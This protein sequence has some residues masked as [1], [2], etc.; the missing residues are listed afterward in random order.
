[1]EKIKNLK[2]LIKSQEEFRKQKD[3][4]KCI[5][6]FKE[7]IELIKNL[8]DNNKFDIISKLFLFEDQTNY[9]K[10][11][12]FN[13]L[14]KNNLF[15]KSKS[16]K[17]KYYQLLID[18]FNNNKTNDHSEQVTKLKELYDKS[19][20][21]NF[22]ELDMYI[23]LFIA[24]KDIKNNVDN[25][26][27]DITDRELVFEFD[28]PKKSKK[29]NINSIEIQINNDEVKKSDTNNNNNND[30]ILISPIQT[31][32]NSHNTKMNIEEINN[33][34]SEDIIIDPNSANI[35]KLALKKYKPNPSLPMIILSVS[36]NL[37]S[38]Q[39]LMLINQTFKKFNYVNISTIKDT[40]FDNLRIYEYKPKNCF[41]YIT[42]IF[43]TKGKCI[44]NQFHVYSSLKRDENNFTGGINSV[45]KDSYERKIAIKSIKG[46]ESNLVNFL[47]RFLK[48]FCQN[49]ERIK[50]IK[51][52]SCFDKYALDNILYEIIIKEKKSKI[53]MKS[54][55]INL[56]NK[57]RHRNYK[58]IKNEDESYIGLNKSVTTTT[59]MKYFEIFKI[60]SN[61]GYGLGKKIA[62]FVEDFKKRYNP[63]I[64]NA[65]SID[66]RSIMMKIIKLFEFET[67]NL[68][69][70]FNNQNNEYDTNYI[71]IASEQYIFNKIYFLLFN[72]YCEKYKKQ[73]E[74]IIKIQQEINNKYKTIEI[75]NK[76]QVNSIY[77]GK[78]QEPFKS[79]V[80]I[81]EQIQF[82]KFLHKKFEILTQASLEIRKCILE[83]TDG[84]FELE[85]MDDELPII[86]FISTQVK[87]DNFIAELNMLDDYI[88]CSMRDNLVQN[89]MVTNLLSSL[90][91]LT[92]SWNSETENF[93]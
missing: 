29:N 48:S 8:N 44:Y 34:I 79:V 3:D 64:K 82:E 7:I 78:E 71:M 38:F 47:I 92:K 39:F 36:A 69:T 65:E 70:S 53:N 83:Y 56:K 85:S 32:F 1:M 31:K 50:I 59:T 33:Y 75:C 37:N 55:L 22:E 26:N 18:S 80:N 52:S 25:F 51:Q 20:L 16:S 62:D 28:K 81:I 42:E 2:D 73:N 6:I 14:L 88:K 89:K 60:L 66:T 27:D 35:D 13:D 19:D 91:Y 21:N 17:R 74:K 45:L 87:V 49:I 5:S 12:I 9:T 86:I 40:E 46:V 41:N 68:N 30:I 63:P 76:L 24:E 54:K 58:K 90:L 15:I 11:F 84:R 67:S 10:L 43:K 72:I 93:D 23:E 61:P 77:L 57:I 4:N